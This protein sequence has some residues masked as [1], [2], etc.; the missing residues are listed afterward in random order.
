MVELANLITLTV[1]YARFLKRHGV[2]VIG[3]DSGMRRRFLN[4]PVF[5]AAV[6]R[7]TLGEMLRRR[8]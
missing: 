5:G 4:G 7:Q 2:T 3:D 8:T 6:A 1:R